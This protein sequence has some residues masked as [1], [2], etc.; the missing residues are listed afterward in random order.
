MRCHFSVSV[1]FN[2]TLCNACKHNCNCKKQN[3]K[4]AEVKNEAKVETK[5][6]A[7]PKPE[8][9]AEKEAKKPAKAPVAK[10]K[11]DIIFDED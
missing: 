9:K 1:N 5:T 2:L 7:E 11:L 4:K 8:V 10:K 3:E 6:E